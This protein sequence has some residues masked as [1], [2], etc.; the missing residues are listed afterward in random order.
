MVTTVV[1]FGMRSTV[2]MNRGAPSSDG[3]LDQQPL[4]GVDL[5]LEAAHAAVEQAIDR[6]GL[7]RAQLAHVDRRR[8]R[9]RP[10]PAYRRPAT[11]WFSNRCAIVVRAGTKPVRKSESFC[12]RRRPRDRRTVSAG[13]AADTIQKADDRP[14]TSRPMAGMTTDLR[15]KSS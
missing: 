11:M 12:E 14:T 5:V 6:V 2:A 4:V 10:A 3:A 1:C 15:M 8:D 9:R 13:S 7:A